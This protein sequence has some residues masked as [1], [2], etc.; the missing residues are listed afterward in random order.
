RTGA[1]SITSAFANCAA[2]VAFRRSVSCSCVKVVACPLTINV[3]SLPKKE[4]LP[5]A[6]LT[7]GAKHWHR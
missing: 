7:T 5:V 6:S 2:G 1:D 4:M 3:T